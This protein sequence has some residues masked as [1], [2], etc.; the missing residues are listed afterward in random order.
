MKRFLLLLLALAVLPAAASAAE[1]S[2]PIRGAMADLT[3]V[4]GYTQEEAEAFTFDVTQTDTTYEVAYYDPAHPTWVYT[5]ITD[6]KTG[7]Y[8]SATTPFKGPDYADYPGEGAVRDGLR[9]ARENSWFVNRSAENRAAFL[10]WMEQ[11]GVQAND[12]LKNGLETGAIT[13]VRAVH[14]YFTSC[15]GDPS[16]WSKALLEWEEAELATNG[17]GTGSTQAMVT[18]ALPTPIAGIH[19][20]ES[21]NKSGSRPVTVTEFAG[22]TPADLQQ[23]LSHPMLEG[24][25]CVCGAYYNTE[26]MGIYLS[27]EAGLLVLDKDGKRML[28]SLSR[29]P[30]ATDWTVL[31]IGEAALL[32]SR[33]LYITY[34]AGDGIFTLSYPISDTQRESFAVQAQYS[35]G[36]DPLFRLKEYRRVNTA[37]GE[38]VSITVTSS[39]T[40]AEDAELWYRVVA[41]DAAGNTTDEQYPVLM[42][43][44]LE[45]INADAFPKTAEACR[46]ATGY[47]VPDGY[48]VACGA[49]LRKQTSSHSGD[50]GTYQTGVL[51]E[52][53]GTEA[54]DPYPWYHVRIGSVEGYMSGVYV[55]TPG[56]DCSMR[57][58][59]QSLPLPVAK[60]KKDVALKKGVGWFDGAVTTLPAGTKMHVLAKR[61][62]WLHVMVPQ[63][64]EPGWL[65]DINGTDGY[66]KAKDVVTAATSLQLDWK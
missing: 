43:R 11:W 61:G 19:R 56:S 29:A 22:E 60:V 27:A 37:T 10:A 54:G 13:G 57:P 66:V 30:D 65:M 63:N 45:L 17:F 3:E 59:R 46:A 1:P 48:A 36:S 5:S 42:P 18:E 41:T 20:Y 21:A 47:T 58:L 6:T 28:V 4:F 62:G 25:A 8:V 50:L 35:E 26:A 32:S 38:R 23:A 51:M 33:S 53:L 39:L 31:P 7:Q 49:H 44:Y 34:D 12:T 24:W 15:Y 16:G 52:V 2:A 14:A 40:S 55:D 64:G 9:A